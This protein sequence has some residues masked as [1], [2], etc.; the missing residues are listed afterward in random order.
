M[1]Y[2]KEQIIEQLGLANAAQN[3]QDMAY[4]S[5]VNTLERRVMMTMADRLDDE[6]L[7]EFDTVLKESP[8]H[9]DKWLHE[10]FPDQ[11][12]LFT[13][14]INALIAQIKESAQEMTK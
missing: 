11:Q 6:Q 8:E 3:V 1:E 7:A 4:Q 12:T 5:F 13:D 10:K 14:Q 2:T 9:A